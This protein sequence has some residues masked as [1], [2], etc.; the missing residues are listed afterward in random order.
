MSVLDQFC[1][2]KFVIGRLNFL[3]KYE[4]AGNSHYLNRDL[5]EASIYIYIEVWCLSSSTTGEVDA[6]FQ[7]C[8][9]MKSKKSDAR[10]AR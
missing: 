4:S 10:P 9:N 6:E 2:S 8:M 5:Y 1:L 3:S 7:T